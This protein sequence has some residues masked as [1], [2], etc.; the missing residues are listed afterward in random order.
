M[1]S[2]WNVSN[3][4]STMRRFSSSSAACLLLAARR[5]ATRGG[6]ES[7]ASFKAARFRRC[8]ATLYLHPL[9]QHLEQLARASGVGVRAYRYADDMLILARDRRLARRARRELRA[10]LRGLRMRLNNRKTR[11]CSVERRALNGSGC[12]WSV[13]LRLGPNALSFHTS[14]PTDR[15]IKMLH[16]IR[17]IT[18]P[19]SSR[20]DADAFNL[21][22]WIA[23]LNTQLRDWRAAYLYAENAP[24]VFPRSRRAR[25]RMRGRAVLTPSWAFAG[26]I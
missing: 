23:S 26:E 3:V 4:L 13:A 6:G 2:S 8:C 9:D 18:A 7:A 21:P 24:V 19:P 12:A 25:P 14:F 15:V 10:A 11:A 20:V 5:P 17:E 1:R 22:R 16:R